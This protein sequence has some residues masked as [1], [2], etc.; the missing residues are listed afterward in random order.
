MKD[1][2]LKQARDAAKNLPNWDD[3]KCK[4]SGTS[5]AASFLMLLVITGF[6]FKAW[7]FCITARRKYEIVTVAD[8]TIGEI[9]FQQN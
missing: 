9:E 4:S 3:K 5:L 7:I 2:A 6:V 1:T 8:W